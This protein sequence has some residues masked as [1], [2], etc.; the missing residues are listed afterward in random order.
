LAIRCGQAVAP[1]R[2]EAGTPA[3]VEDAPDS[4]S[5]SNPAGT[6]GEVA[7]FAVISAIVDSLA[8]LRASHIEMP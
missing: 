4:A 1:R 7:T 6:D 5:K 3:F 2:D 8:E